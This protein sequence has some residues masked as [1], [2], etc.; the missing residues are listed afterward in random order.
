MSNTYTTP[1]PGCSGL[2]EIPAELAGETIQCQDCAQ[3]F[4]APRPV[5]KVP[6]KRPDVARGQV[7]CPNC[8]DVVKPIRKSKGSFAVGLLLC[9]L[10]VVP[11]VIYF[12]VMSGYT[13][14]C[15]SCGIQTGKD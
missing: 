11:G 7:R 1:C 5:R 9:L 14:T 6:V 3:T 10:A 4:K 12:I 15:P 13:Y 8:G 2:L